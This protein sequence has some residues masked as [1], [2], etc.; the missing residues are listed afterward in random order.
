[1]SKFDSMDIAMKFFVPSINIVRGRRRQKKVDFVFGEMKERS[2]T[3][4]Y[5]KK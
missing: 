5:Q 4:T 3:K 1:M 2:A